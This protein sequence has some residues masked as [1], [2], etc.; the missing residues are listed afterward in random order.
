MSSSSAH[1]EQ[2]QT[3]DGEELFAKMAS[4]MDGKFNSLQI[5]VKTLITSIADVS[6]TVKKLESQTRSNECNIGTLK[7][8]VKEIK[9]SNK[10][11]IL[12]QVNKI[13][14][15]STGHNN[16][17]VPE[18]PKVRQEIEKLKEIN[19]ARKTK[20]PNSLCP[21]YDR[22]LWYVRPSLRM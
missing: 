9:N 15:E 6:R 17:I 1:Q 18:M 4:Y 10:P 8:E 20:Q 14:Q 12:D 7:Q 5:T 13:I 11:Q 22:G 16:V 21:L 3:F 2:G 19:L